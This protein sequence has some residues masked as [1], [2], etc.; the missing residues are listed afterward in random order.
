MKI[1]LEG[2]AQDGSPAML[3]LLP[4][5]RRRKR[6]GGVGGMHTDQVAGFLG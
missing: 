4:A 1:V 5:D 3:M 2:A 6:S